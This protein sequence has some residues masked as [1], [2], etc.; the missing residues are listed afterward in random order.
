[1][2]IVAHADKYLVHYWK[3]AQHVPLCFVAGQLDGRTMKENAPVWDKL[4]RTP[5][6]DTTVVEYQGRGHEPFHD[7][8]LQLFDWMGRKSRQAPPKEFECET[9]RPWDNYFWWLECREFPEQFMMHPTDWSGRRARPAQ[10]AGKVQPDNR[11]VAKTTAEQT[12]IWLSPDVVDFSKPVR[13]T[14]NGRKLALPEG[15]VR[16]DPLVLL[17]DVRTRADRQ[18]PFWAKIEAK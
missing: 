10:V 15:G 12:T 7:E 6:F 16:A 3:N 4:L 18:R 14:F 17:E 5:G 1:M 13:V 9:M 11:L 2:P 8:I